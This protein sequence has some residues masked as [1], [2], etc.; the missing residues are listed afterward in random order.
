MELT[1]RAALDR[2]ALLLNLD[3]FNGQV[4]HETIIESLLST[5]A[6]VCMSARES[7]TPGG[8][9]ALV[10][11]VL[12]LAM[13][14]IGVELDVRDT[15]LLMAQ[16]PLRGS[17]I[18][19][20]LEDH[21]RTTFP[22]V[23][24][25]AGRPVDVTFVVG[26]SDVANPHDVVRASASASGCRVGPAEASAPLEFDGTWPVGPIAAGIAGAA[27]AVRA[28]VRQLATKC[29]R[30]VP[31][32]LAPPGCM[33]NIEV[34]NG[35]ASRV[36][37]GDVTFIS[38]GAITQSSLFVLSRVDGLTGT[39]TVFDDDVGDISNLNRY[40]L[41]DTNGIGEPKVDTFACH[42]TSDFPIS[43]QHRR[44]RAGDVV[45]GERVVVGADDIEVRWDAYNDTPEW[46]TI[47][48]TSHLFSEVSTHDPSTA[49]SGCVHDHSDDAPDVIPTIS[50]VSGWAGLITASTLLDA[51]TAGRTA[52]EQTWSFPLGLAGRFGHRTLPIAPN[53]RCPIRCDAS[54]PPRSA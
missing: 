14:G 38:A 24:I 13:N 36:D 30:Q 51:V 27:E 11:L 23:A 40:P 54:R 7:T 45:Q 48:A 47:G 26:A 37:V 33:V 35:P 31:L 15:P 52:G 44:Y 39:G 12:H 10:T 17:Q 53:P 32:V 50:V 28:A 41:L 5:T 46:M 1:G 22:W 8:Q 42:A 9:H 4:D 43:A 2:T 21:I 49:C 18:G 3:M 25:N 16:P 20:A 34:G 29:G 19:S 6:R